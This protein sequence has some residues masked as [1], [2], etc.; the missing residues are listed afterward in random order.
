MKDDMWENTKLVDPTFPINRFHIAK[1]GPL[2][3]RPHW[4]EHFEMIVV[5][6][7]TVSVHIGANRVQ[8][9]EGDLLF[10]NSGE[11]HA[12]FADPNE[13]VELYAIVFNAALL[14]TTSHAMEALSPYL[15]GN[16]LFEHTIG[17]TAPSYPDAYRAIHGIVGEFERRRPGY[18]L[19]VKGHCLLLFVLMSRGHTADT[20]GKRQSE[21]WRTKAA[22]FKNLIVHIEQHYDRPWTIPQAAAMVHLSPYHFCA[23]FKQ[24]TGMTFVR[25]VNLQRIYEAERLLRHSALPVTDVSDRV[26]CSS[27]HAFN[28][29]FR[30]YK[31]ISPT[32]YRTAHRENQV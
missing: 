16:R 21:L 3:F 11:L 7:G 10:V 9:G 31:G 24:L 1:K 14:G 8:A 26:G 18:E 5:T 23:T 4:H 2:I 32:A 17:K 25:F 13:P 6:K 15:S 20:P 29:L 30:K 22:R 27:I 19:A 28:K 12:A